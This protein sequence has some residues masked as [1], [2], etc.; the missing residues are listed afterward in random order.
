M[1]PGFEFENWAVLELGQVLQHQGVGAFAQANSSKVGDM[2]LDGKL[3]LVN[4]ASLIKRDDETL[5]GEKQ[6]YLPIQVK[7]KDKAGRPDMDGFAHALR[8]DKRRHGFFISWEFT[9]DALKEIDRLGKL[10][11]G[12]GGETPVHIIPVRVDELLT[13][14]FKLELLLWQQG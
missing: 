13:E 12:E 14:S 10:R 1:L 4:N 5:F 11:G 9:R 3:Y 7:N 6:P 8:R 2:G